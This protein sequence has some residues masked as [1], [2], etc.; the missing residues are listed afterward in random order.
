M[1][2]TPESGVTDHSFIMGHYRRLSGDTLLTHGLM[3]VQKI[4]LNR[5]HYVRSFP[6]RGIHFKTRPGNFPTDLI[7]LSSRYFSYF[8]DPLSKLYHYHMRGFFTNVAP[9]TSW[10]PTPAFRLIRRI[11]IC[12]G[13]PLFLLCRGVYYSFSPP[14]VV[15]PLQM[16]ILPQPLALD[17]F[18]YINIHSHVP[19]YSISSRQLQ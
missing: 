14:F 16:V 6:T 9:V 5:P 7:A 4:V 10:F 17:G 1:G 19:S 3:I 12:L 13:L 11:L 15:H 2:L 18:N 8:Y